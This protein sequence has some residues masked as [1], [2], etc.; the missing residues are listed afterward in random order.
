LESA[1]PAHH[2]QLP[3]RASASVQRAPSVLHLFHPFPRDR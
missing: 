3:G 2:R 1:R